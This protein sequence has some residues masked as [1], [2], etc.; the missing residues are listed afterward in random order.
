MPGGQMPQQQADELVRGDQPTAPVHAAHAVGVAVGHQT[1][2]V[3]MFFEERLTAR[4]VPRDR[5]GIDAAKH[6]VVRAV[7]GRDPARRAGEQLLEAARPHAKQRLVRQPQSGPGDE[8]KVHE[9]LERRVM[10]RAHVPEENPSRAQGVG[11]LQEA[12]GMAVEPC[13][14][15]PA[16][17]GIARTSVVRLELEPVERGRI[18]AG[19]DHHAADGLP[20]FHRER[21]RR[22]RRRLGREDDL[23]IVS[24]EHF[25]RRLREAVGEEPPVIADD[26]P[27]RASEEGGFRIPDFGLPEVGGGLRH[28]RD[29]GKREIV[30]DDRAPAVG[31]EG[32][33]G[34]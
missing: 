2:V 31:A 3:R 27:G 9:P 22:R 33:G 20:P 5:F 15:R 32:D 29:I 12:D 34:H 4:V 18:V 7:E 24:G 11:E 25:G 10:R 23:E 19:R 21:N 30:R 14:H 16:G 8:R 26:H 1:Q 6:H 28:P 17:R 13:F